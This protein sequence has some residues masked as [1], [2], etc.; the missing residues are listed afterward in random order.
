GGFVLTG[1]HAL[2]YTNGANPALLV[3]TDR[4]YDGAIYNLDIATSQVQGHHSHDHGSPICTLALADINGDGED[5]IVA[6]NY[7]VHTGSIRVCGYLF[8]RQTAAELWRS[9]NLAN[10]FGGVRSLATGDLD[11]DS[12]DDI[13][14]IA[15]NST[16]YGGGFLFQFTGTKHTQWQSNDSDYTAVAIDDVDGDGH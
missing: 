2:A 1:L 4:L 11:G 12:I 3:G 15:S 5:E 7:G 8:D 14:A 9:I 6:G 10:T 16:W 13:A